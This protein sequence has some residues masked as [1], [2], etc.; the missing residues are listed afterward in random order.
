MAMKASNCILFST[1]LLFAITASAQ[2][3]PIRYFY[4]DLGRLT[5][6]VDQ[7][8]NFAVY[9]YDAVGNLLSITRSTTPGGNALAILS[10]T[11]QKGSVGQTVTIDGQGFSATPSGNSV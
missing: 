5:K 3:T 2:S 9:S 11:P 7:N 6:V 4:D 10:V 1:A 8:G